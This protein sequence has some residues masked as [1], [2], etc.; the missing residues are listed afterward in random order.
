MLLTPALVRLLIE[1]QSCR[2]KASIQQCSRLLSS[3]VCRPLGVAS[4]F[5]LFQDSINKG[6]RSIIH[7][8]F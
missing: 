4:I 1:S 3:V 8:Q 7:L 6:I 2:N 5:V